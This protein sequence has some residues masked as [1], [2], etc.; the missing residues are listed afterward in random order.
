MNSLV[1][2]L[3]SVS[4]PQWIFAA[5]KLASQKE[6]A[7][8][9]IFYLEADFSCINESLALD[10]CRLARYADYLGAVTTSALHQDAY[11]SFQLACETQSYLLLL[12]EMINLDSETGE[13]EVFFSEEMLFWLD[14]LSEKNL[15]IAEE[16]VE[17]VYRFSEQPPLLKASHLLLEYSLRIRQWLSLGPEEWESADLS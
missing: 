12:P 11:A 16:F 7:S 17:W 14:W 2:M 13:L 1:L 4:S 8:V 5:F 9:Q 6:L 15:D 3:E 10:L